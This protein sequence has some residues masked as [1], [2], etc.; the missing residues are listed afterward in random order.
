MPMWPKDENG[1][2]MQRMKGFG[3]AL[4]CVV[5]IA[6]LGGL[7]LARGGLYI[8][9]YEGDVL[10]L[11]EIVVRMA[12]GQRPHQDFMTP[13]GILATWPIAVFV[14]AGFGIGMSVHWA[15]IAVALV[16][17]PAVIWTAVSRFSGVFAHLFAIF[18]MVLVL[19]LV[20]GE[21]DPHVSISMHYNR[22][23]WAFSFVALALAFL[24]PLGRDKAMLDGALIGICMALV[25]LIKVTFVVALAPGLIVALVLR[26]AGRSL[27]VALGVGTVT[28]A[29]AT[30]IV[31]WSFW[32]AYVGDL[33]ATATSETRAHPGRP[34]DQ[35]LTAPMLLG[36]HLLTLLAVVLL[37]QGG[38]PAAGLSLLV[39]FPGLVYI[40]YQNFGNDPQW[41]MIASLLLLMVRPDAGTRNAWGWDLRQG[42]GA[43]ACAM[44]AITSPSFM[45]MVYSPFRHFSDDPSEYVHMFPRSVQHDDIFNSI[46]RAYQVTLQIAGEARAGALE[47]YADLAERGDPTVL[48][49]ET[50]PDCGFQSGFVATSEATV[51]ALEAAGYTIGKRIMVADLLSNLPLFSDG[52]KWVEGGAPWRYDGAP[53]IDSA[54]YVLVP[55]CAIN[56]AARREILKA[57]ESRGITLK[58]VYRDP[59]FVLLEKV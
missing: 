15:Q 8:D 32:P 2:A 21:A 12:E 26:G 43:I 19:A 20:Y 54:A 44:L 30:L 18:C 7:S 5:A 50:L 29:L 34:L 47:R 52:I 38:R 42:V 59:L 22:W 27:L 48:L 1:A 45:N 55:L 14:K 57:I 28:L 24:P 16:L 41:L 40:T 6:V 58:E 25:I 51:E 17:A 35:L 56:L 46:K 53:G 49:G 37:R 4:T 10:H 9:R 3:P 36:A 39:L 23:A 11:V 13:I 31:G 33:I